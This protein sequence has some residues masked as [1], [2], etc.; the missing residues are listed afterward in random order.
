MNTKMREVETEIRAA[1]AAAQARGLVL[2]RGITN[3]TTPDAAEAAL[4]KAFEEFLAKRA[5]RT[6]E[7]A[8]LARVDAS[9]APDAV[10]MLQRMHARA[11][12]SENHGDAPRIGSDES[13]AVLRAAQAER[14]RHAE[15]VAALRDQLRKAE[16]ERVMWEKTASVLS[17]K[18]DSL[19]ALLPD[20]R[21]LARWAIETEHMSDH[22]NTDQ[23]GDV[24]RN[25]L[26]ALDS[27]GGEGEYDETDE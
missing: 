5:R 9:P 19:R 3:E 26:A 27:Q 4:C 12:H 24:G 13:L 23:I 15:E 11:A 7:V 22:V 16:G 18:L 14:A 17:G 1:V 20:V 6:K 2:T 21:A 25:I 10:T 8:R